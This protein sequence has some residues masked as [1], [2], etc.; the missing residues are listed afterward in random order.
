[1]MPWTEQ[2]QAWLDDNKKSLIDVV[3]KNA[4]RSDPLGFLRR[5][6]GLVR[7]VRLNFPEATLRQALR[8]GMDNKIRN[9]Q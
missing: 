1:M 3:L 9:Y 2:V 8:V 7:L 4:G 5:V 6:P